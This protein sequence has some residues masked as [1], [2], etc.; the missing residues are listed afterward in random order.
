VSGFLHND[1]GWDRLS[2]TEIPASSTPLPRFRNAL[3]EKACV[4][5][6]NRSYYLDTRAEW[7]AFKSSLG[8]WAREN[9]FRRARRLLESDAWQFRKVEGPDELDPALD[10][11][12]R[13]HQARWQSRG[14]PGAFA[15]TGASG[16]LKEAARAS[17]SE[18]RLRLWT[19]AEGDRI[20]AAQ[21]G[22]VDNG[23]Y[24]AF[25][26][27]FDQKHARQGLGSVMNGMCIRA[28]VED[29]EVHTYDFMG[30]ADAYK[31]NWSKTSR[32]TVSLSYLRPS[33]N[34]RI[35]EGIDRS[36]SIGKSLLRTT[37][38]KR[39]RVA[40]HKLMIRRRYYRG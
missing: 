25:Q 32:E 12:I 37:V 2:L 14:E 39:I 36:V 24:H 19:L 35:S 29:P 23:V 4:A 40:G 9:V 3:G 17:L 31:Q 21:I 15:L 38:P 5:A 7:E 20:A 34:L 1:P 6:C 13:L 18:G 27:G 28:C 30:G 11:L 33:V 22:F 16:F 10:G 8:K 26:A